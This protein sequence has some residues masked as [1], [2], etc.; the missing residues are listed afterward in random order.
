MTHLHVMHFFNQKKPKI[1][2]LPV[3][4]T[5]KPTAI[6]NRNSHVYLPIVS[7]FKMGMTFGQKYLSILVPFTAMFIGMYFDWEIKEDMRS[8]HNKSKL[9]GGRDLKPGEKLW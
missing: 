8:F 9:F 7:D 1:I 6:D 2:M 5:L 3:I 4:I